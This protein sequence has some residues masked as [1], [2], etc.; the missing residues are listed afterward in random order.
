MGRRRGGL[1][2]QER[3][4]APLARPRR[5]RPPARCAWVTVGDVVNI[6]RALEESQTWA[7]GRSVSTRQPTVVRHRRLHAA[8]RNGAGA[9]GTG[10]RRSGARALRCPRLNPDGRSRWQPECVGGSWCRAVRSG[11]AT[12]RASARLSP[13]RGWHCDCQNFGHDRKLRWQS[14]RR[15]EG[16]CGGGAKARVPEDHRACHAGTGRARPRAVRPA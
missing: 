11:T 6:A 15:G 8:N 16:R 9:E 7:S 13:A 14:D 3:R 2:R 1:V 10:L 5:R 12:A 4:A